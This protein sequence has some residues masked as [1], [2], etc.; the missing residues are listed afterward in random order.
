MDLGVWEGVLSEEIKVRYPKELAERARNPVKARAP[1]GES[2]L[3]VADRVIAAVNEIGI[4]HRHEDILI[5]AHG[6]SLA[7]I[8]CFA[9]GIPLE[10]LYEYVPNNAELNHVEWKT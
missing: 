8:I 2:P 10:K 7:I 4:R 3:Q 6:I 9:Q 1:G 5:V